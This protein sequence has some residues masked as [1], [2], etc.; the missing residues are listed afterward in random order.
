MLTQVLSETI[1]SGQP[2]S[3]EGG[4][5]TESAIL[6]LVSRSWLYL[7][8]QISEDTLQIKMAVMDKNFKAAT[9][10]R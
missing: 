10:S 3:G 5:G 1:L 4:F 9:T 6:S 8:E 7:K 2:F